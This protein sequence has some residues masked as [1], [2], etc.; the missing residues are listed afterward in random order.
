LS[1]KKNRRAASPSLASYYLASHPHRRTPLCLQK[2][3]KVNGQTYIAADAYSQ[4]LL[5]NI[6]QTIKEALDAFTLYN[7]YAYGARAEE[8]DAGLRQD[9]EETESNLRNKLDALKNL[10]A[11]L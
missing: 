1:R 6:K 8:L 10:A 2:R 9:L 5:G 3:I 11:R 7:G 4:Q